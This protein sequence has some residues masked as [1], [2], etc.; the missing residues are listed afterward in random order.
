[1]WKAD[2]TV[3]P[4]VTAIIIPALNIYK[5]SKKATDMGNSVYR[6]PYKHASLDSSLNA[7]NHWI[8]AA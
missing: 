4:E 7:I 8:T 5:L 1:M 3:V 6:R 2:K